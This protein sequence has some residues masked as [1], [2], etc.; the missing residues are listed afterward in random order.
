VEL[1][2][3]GGFS[4]EETARAL[5]LSPTTVKRHWSSARLWLHH[6]MSK[7]TDT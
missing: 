2:L 7:A 6:E 3:F 4:I 1:R 5:S